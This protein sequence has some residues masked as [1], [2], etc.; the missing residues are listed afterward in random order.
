MKHT[1]LCVDDEVDNL[2]ALERLFR[3]KYTVL[4]SSSG[5]A[6]L[7]MLQNRDPSEPEIA[8]IITDQ[9]MPGLNGVEL[10]Q[11]VLQ[12]SPNTM[13]ILLTGY[14]DIESIIDAVN[15]GQIYRYL[16]KPWDPVDL[17]GTVDRAAERYDMQKELGE[18][19]RDLEKALSELQTLDRAK[20]QFMILV[21]H[22]LKTPLTA[23]LSFIQLLRET[24]L[25]EEQDLFTARVLKSAEKLKSI[26]DDVLIVV[27][28]EAQTLKPRIQP[29]EDNTLS[30]YLPAD[31]QNSAA[32]K[33]VK[34]TSQWT[35]KKIVADRSMLE[36]IFNRLLHNAIKFAKNESLIEVR[37]VVVQP[38]RVRFSV[39]N[40]G[41]SISPSMINKIMNPFLLDED[42]MNH[43]VG[44][45]LGLT[46]CHSYLKTL[47]SSLHIENRPAGVEVHFELSCL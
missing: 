16:N 3:N 44:M 42:V 35:N 15:D 22:E 14:T 36:Q 24:K 32:D 43:S 26:V 10:L 46:I 2:D 13:R 25:D 34:I 20:S 18:K 38:H 33:K 19:R 39:Y 37:A 29:F 1:I 47:A 21:N 27:A 40:Q 23:I 17:M 30:F 31:A 4:K 8:V 9:R 28:S 5:T 7:E 11:H 6:A 45:G 12:L 41:P